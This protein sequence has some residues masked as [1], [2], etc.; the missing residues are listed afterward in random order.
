MQFQ[1]FVLRREM[2][3]EGTITPDTGS[4]EWA[5][6]SELWLAE[7]CKLQRPKRLRE[8]NANPL[9]LTGHGTTLRID[10]GALVIRQGF[11]HYP[12]R[13]ECHQLFRGDLALPRMIVLLDGSGSLS[14]DVL[15]WLGE[16][17][18]ALARVTG[19]GGLAVMASGAGFTADADKLR[20]QL[21]IQRDAAKRMEFAC[22]IISRKLENSIATLQSQFPESRSARPSDGNS[23]GWH[24]QTKQR[25]V[26]RDERTSRNR[27]RKRRRL[28]CCVAKYRNAVD[29]SGPLSGF[30]I[31]GEPIVR[32]VR[33]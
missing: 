24:C 7:S 9:I 18:V 6:R 5:V 3:C 4:D 11:T 19:D 23:Q 12:Q 1:H 2:L 21:D 22:K 15:N 32:A 29:G 10:H 20:W 26:G 33:S 25:T 31:I 27:G 13:Q 30:R 8:R 17:G 16:Q 28:F 14:F